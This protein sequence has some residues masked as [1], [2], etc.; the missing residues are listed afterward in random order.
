LTSEELVGIGMFED[1]E[2]RFSLANREP[3]PT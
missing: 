3:D 1:E 2:L